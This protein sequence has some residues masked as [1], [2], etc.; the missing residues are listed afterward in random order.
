MSFVQ[1][2]LDQFLSTYE[3]NT[4]NADPTVVVTQ[5]ADTFIAAGP[6]GTMV[7]PATAFAEKLPARKQLFRKAG[8]QSSRLVSRKDSRIGERYVLVDTEWRMD[9][10]PEG[11]PALTIPV[12][13]SLLIDMGGPEPK[14]LAYLPHQD[15]FQLMRD[16][17]LLPAS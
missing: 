10:A 14:I 5:F 13:S 2:T 11:K 1:E 17:G 8:L 12:G 16:S 15:I 7:V 9:F 4:V 3:W 6:S